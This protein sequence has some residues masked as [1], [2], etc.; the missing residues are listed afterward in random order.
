MF[1]RT[2]LN[3]RFLE[4]RNCA[5]CRYVLPCSN[6]WFC[7]KRIQMSWIKSKIVVLERRIRSL[8]SIQKLFYCYFKNLKVFITSKDLPWETLQ[9]S[10]YLWIEKYDVPKHILTQVLCMYVGELFLFLFFFIV[11][12]TWTPA[13][14]QST[15]ILM[16]H[17]VFET[18]RYLWAQNNKIICITIFKLGENKIFFNYS[19]SC[20]RYSCK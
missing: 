20:T 18:A 11:F 7:L 16:W 19:S 15:Y 13:C 5:N 2:N 14:P 3:D 12:V 10:W 9:L 8:S 4:K 17:K 1:I 6:W